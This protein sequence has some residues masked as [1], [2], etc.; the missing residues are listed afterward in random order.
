MAHHGEA[1]SY[2]NDQSVNQQDL[3][4]TQTQQH[5]QPL[6]IQYQPP[7]HPSP[8]PYGEHNY[9][10]KNEQNYYDAPPTYGATFVPPQTNKQ[11]FQQTFKVTKPKWND[12]WAGILVRPAQRSLL[13]VNADECLIECS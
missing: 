10:G 4:L 2:Y 5:R 1:D 8:Q 12:L 13:Q 9:G 6:P 3:Q 11:D 7:A